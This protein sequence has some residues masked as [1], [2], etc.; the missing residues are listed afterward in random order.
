MRT[1]GRLVVFTVLGAL[2]WTAVAAELPDTTNTRWV[3]VR[4]GRF[5]VYSNTSD[6]MTVQ[7]A[8][9]L[10][11]FNTAIEEMSSFR[12]AALDRMRIFVF[13]DDSSFDP[14]KVL[15]EGRPAAIGG[16]FLSGPDGTAIAVNAT[17][18][19]DAS[20]VLF[21]EYVHAL[22]AEVRPNLPVW[23]SEGLA[24]FYESVRIDE[25]T[26]TLGIAPDRYL[27]LLQ[28][29]L[30]IPLEEMLSADRESPLYNDPDRSGFFYAQSWAV[31]HSLLMG[32]ADR[33]RELASYFENLD[34]GMAE[35][36]AF[37]SSFEGGLDTVENEVL[38]HIRSQPIP[39]KRIVVAVAAP[40]TDTIAEISR[41]RVLTLLGGLLASHSPPLPGAAAHLEEALVLDPG[42]GRAAA[43]LGVIAEKEDRIDDAQSLYRRAAASEPDDSWILYRYGTF[44]FRRTTERSEAIELLERSLEAEPGFASA[45]GVLTMAY[46]ET[47]RVDDARLETAER[48]HRLLPTDRSVSMALLTL[49]LRADRRERALELASTAFGPRDGDRRR[50]VAMI[51]ANDLAR[52]RDALILGDLPEAERRLDLARELVDASFAPGRLHPQID[53]LADTI[54]EHRAAARLESASKLAASG[55]D[56]LALIELDE[57]LAERP[58]GS[59]ADAARALRTRILDPD[60]PVAPPPGV[61]I[62]PLTSSGEIDELNRRLA[63]GDLDAA[64]ELLEDL[65]ARVS[66][67]DRSWIDLKIEEIRRTAEHNRFAEAYN[68]AV[69]AL[70]DGRRDHAETI[71][72]DLLATLPDGR[73]ADEVRELISRIRS[74]R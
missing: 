23:L 16:Y 19:N 13:R 32:T 62:V 46:A 28:G 68:R 41:P 39:T 63:A 49:N 57:L 33:R 48:A 15:H 67:D 44:L 11:E 38:G 74:A 72:T 51:A 24:T 31:T 17:S 64:L 43:W 2:A 37:Q 26:V 22:M 73:Q 5:T 1:T 30:P 29:G 60:A 27:S 69:D 4:T 56:A 54:A 40:D 7:I 25:G 18:R 34:E 21:H 71:L 61:R 65:D 53:E 50:A 52:T 47:G 35:P 59:T 45:M 14:Y 10:G 12:I 36:E 8:A 42:N 58:D 20:T 3:E 9:D 55:A 6:A 70:N 66:A